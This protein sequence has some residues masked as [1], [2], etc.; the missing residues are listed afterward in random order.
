[1]ALIYQCLQTCGDVLIAASGSRLDS[2]STKDGSLLSSW[3]AEHGQ[4]GSGAPVEADHKQDVV[5][6]VDQS[7]E[8]VDSQSSR[9]AKRRRLSNDAE[10]KQTANGAPQ[11]TAS[12]ASNPRFSALAATSDGRHV[13]AVTM[14]DKTIRVFEHDGQ[15][16]L[17]CLSQR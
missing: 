16:R 8:G 1:M 13:I 3:T 7:A 10:D 11:A 4:N 12:P 9:P 2:F 17:G 14:G 15:G 6:N 5:V